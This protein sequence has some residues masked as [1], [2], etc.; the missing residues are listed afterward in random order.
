MDSRQTLSIIAQETS[1][2]QPSRLS[3]TITSIGDGHDFE[4]NVLHDLTTIDVQRSR[5]N[6]VSLK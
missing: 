4:I 6:R 3:S 5:S 2:R 1:V